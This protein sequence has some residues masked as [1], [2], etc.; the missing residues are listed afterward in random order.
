MGAERKYMKYN[1][2]VHH[3]RSIRLKG[4]DYSKKGMCFITICTEN[5]ENILSEIVGAHDCALIKL[6]EIGKIVEKEILRT[7]ELNKNIEIYEY[8]I[9]PNHLHIIINIFAD[10]NRAQSCAPTNNK[11]IGNVIRGIKS[12]VSCQVGYSIWQR[13]FYEHLTLLSAGFIDNKPCR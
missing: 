2:D 7:K 10:S 12:S 6:T 9:M 4:Y 8:I 13:N 5:R 1:P 3:R 11:T